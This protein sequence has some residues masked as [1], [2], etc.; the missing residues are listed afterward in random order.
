MQFDFAMRSGISRPNPLMLL[1]Q[2]A[3]A[4]SVLLDFKTFF[5]F[6]RLLYTGVWG[7]ETTVS[8]GLDG[9]RITCCRNENCVQGSTQ[10]VI[11]CVFFLPWDPSG[12]PDD[13]SNPW[14]RRRTHG[15]P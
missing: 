1:L 7:C 13:Q 14:I 15:R 12:P 9:R 5:F 11:V 10:F 6:F 8:C 3:S 4:R 2:M